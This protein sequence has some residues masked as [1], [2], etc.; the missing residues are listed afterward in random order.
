LKSVPSIFLVLIVSVSLNQI[1]GSR[2]GAG[3]N[4]CA[5]PTANQGAA[6]RSDQTADNCA[7][8]TAMMVPLMAISPLTERYA[9]YC[10][11]KQSQADEDRKQTFAKLYPHY[12]YTSSW[13]IVTVRTW[14]Q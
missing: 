14:T 7:L 11:E 10:A 9:S 13:L 8:R 6:A 5:F 3:A 1:S 12:L 4:Q 2:T